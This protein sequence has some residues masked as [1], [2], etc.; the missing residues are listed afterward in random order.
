MRTRLGK[1]DEHN[2]VTF[3]FL[4]RNPCGDTGVIPLA[5]LR[6]MI[7]HTEGVGELPSFMRE[8]SRYAESHAGGYTGNGSSPADYRQHRVRCKQCGESKRT[9]KHR[10]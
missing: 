8:M 6:E 9:P 1:V 3:D 7:D 2:V 10:R 5:V 4:R